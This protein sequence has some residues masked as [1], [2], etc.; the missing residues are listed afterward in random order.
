MLVF[1]LVMLIVLSNWVMP[2][3]LDAPTL[4]MDVGVIAAP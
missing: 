4:I 2:T 1:A 3:Y